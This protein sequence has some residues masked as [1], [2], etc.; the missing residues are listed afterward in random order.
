MRVM[1]LRR[2]VLVAPVLDD[3]LQH[4]E[5]RALS[6]GAFDV[7]DQAQVFPDLD[8][9]LAD[10][11]LA[12]AISADVREFGPDLL[13]PEQ[14]AQ[15]AITEMR[16]DPAHRV[17]LVFGPERTGLSIQDAGRCQ[18]LCSIPG[19]PDYN[20][21]NLSQAVQVLAYELR[22]T[23]LRAELGADRASTDGAQD[24]HT[25]HAGQREIEGLFQHLERALVAIGY[26]DPAHPKKLMPRLRRLFSRTRL[27]TDEVQLLRGLCKLMEKPV[28]RSDPPPGK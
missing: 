11:T 26:L 28:R 6:S 27:E 12:I 18:F 20:S 2:L 14:A 17:A 1:G 15:A 21:L 16:I 10:M 8:Q 22:R 25:P 5:A 7:L 24:A 9:A 23:A 13:D 19:D 4:P 3:V